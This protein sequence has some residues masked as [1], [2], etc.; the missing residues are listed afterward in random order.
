MHISDE[1]LVAGRDGLVSGAEGLLATRAPSTCEN[2]ALINFADSG[3]HGH[4]PQVSPALDT[5]HINGC[6]VDGGQD[7]RVSGIKIGGA[8]LD[9]QPST[10]NGSRAPERHGLAVGG[11]AGRARCNVA[12]NAPGPGHPQGRHQP[13]PGG[14]TNNL[15]RLLAD[16]LRRPRGRVRRPDR[17]RAADRAAHDSG[18]KP[19]CAAR[20][21]ATA[22]AAPGRRG[23]GRTAAACNGGSSPRAVR[24]AEERNVEAQ[25]RELAERHRIP[26]SITSADALREELARTQGRI[27]WLDAEVQR[28]PHDPSLPAVD[29]AERNHLRQLAGGMVTAKLDERAAVITEQAIDLLEK[30]I[31][32]TLREFGVHADEQ[33]VRDT[34]GRQT[35]YLSLGRADAAVLVVDS[36]YAADW[37]RAE[38][39][40][41]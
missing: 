36:R 24:K 33:H 4:A 40:A 1:P 11:P 6:N 26:R 20:R 2:A 39:V 34:V 38:P 16:P 10:Y 3:S 32:A 5:N 25:V 23:A 28:R 37:P 19:G 15:T 12:A 22:V 41:F 8:G 13:V 17:R 31:T 7:A 27:D 29:T 14:V 9:L 18:C 21:A 30:A 35:A